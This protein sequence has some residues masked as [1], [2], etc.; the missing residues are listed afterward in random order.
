MAGVTAARHDTGRG[1]RW[2]VRIVA[3]L[4]VLSL[5]VAIVGTS[6]RLLFS[7]QRMYDFPINR[8]DVP[9]VTSIPRPELLRAMRELRTYLLGPDESLAIAV[10]D[11][12][13]RTGPLFNEREVR[14]MGDVRRVVQGFFRA[15]EA[16]LVVALAYAALRLVG[17]RRRGLAALARLARLSM[18]G[19]LLV[20]VAFGVVT[21]V[22]FEQMFTL[23]HRIGFRNGF[24]QF[25]PLTDR[26]VQIFPDPFW[27]LATALLVG[28]TLAQAV[29]VAL[30]SW[31]YLR[32]VEHTREGAAA[33]VGQAGI[34]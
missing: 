7:A 22:R 2:L 30:V 12:A 16:A 24:W 29:I 9:A 20:G 34:A 14:H 3:V 5:P 10:T 8:Y 6:V 26:L 18:A 23:F 15:Q 25:D 17:E 33:A 19:F 4:F 32:R 31:W 13:G 1:Y 28:L 27:H 11:A 21:A